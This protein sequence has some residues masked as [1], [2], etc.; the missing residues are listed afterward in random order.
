MKDRGFLLA[1]SVL[2]AALSLYGAAARADELSAD[3]ALRDTIAGLDSKVFDAYN[4]CDLETFEQYFSP[5]VEFYHDKGGASFD[6]A[7]VV[8]NTRKYICDK[9]R[10]ELLPATLKVYP[11]KDYG[12]IEEGEH[13]FCEVSSGKCEGG[14]KFLMVWALKDGQWRM[15]RVISYGHRALT[16]QEKAELSKKKPGG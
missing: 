7:T 2:T 12:A 11:I 13:R 10:R 8:S 16:E 3:E 1:A 5:D 15:T 14:A 4:R 6:R 9:V